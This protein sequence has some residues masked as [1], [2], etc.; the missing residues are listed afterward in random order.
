MICLVTCLPGT[1][2]A[3]D[4]PE[5]PETISWN[6]SATIVTYDDAR[7]LFIAEENVVITGGRTRL[8]ADYVEFSNTTKDAVA[9]G[10]VRLISGGDVISC[11][12]MQINLATQIGFIH[13]GTIFIQK[14]HFYIQG[15]NIRKTGKVTYTA[16]KGSITSC[17]GDTPDWKITGKNVRV[18]IE[19]YGLATHVTLWAK[20]I[21]ALY[22]P[23][24]TFPVKT[25]RQTGFLI[26]RVSS[27]DRLGFVYEQPFFW[28]LSPSND[29]TLYAGYL[30][31]RGP[32]I[33]G[34]Y[35]YLSDARSK[36]LFL[37]DF[38]SDDKIDDGTDATENFRFDTTP[39]RTN[40][41]RYWLRM[42]TDQAL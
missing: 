15:E 28:S 41:D 31:D 19:G 35:R 22:S 5:D 26:P 27:S 6:L 38:L 40:T 12:A 7:D 36:G 20:N 34:E 2:Q 42:K 21:P 11:N 17:D 29:A 23:F 25:K 4:L 9:Q 30:S 10:N 32:K 39:L 18:T 33:A 3:V 14:N 16:H 13:K 24:L 1:G 8:E 37:L